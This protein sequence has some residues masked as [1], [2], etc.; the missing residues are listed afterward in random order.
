MNKLIVIAEKGEFKLIE[1][2]QE[3]NL[4]EK[5]IP[6]LVTGVGG[7]NM[8]R[9]LKDLPKDTELINIGYAGSR[10]LPIDQFYQVSLSMLHHPDV[11]YDEPAYPLNTISGCKAVPCYTS[12][13]FVLQS[14]IDD[15]LFD[16]DLGFIMPFGF[17]KVTSFKFVSDNLNFEEHHE[18]YVGE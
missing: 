7:F 1:R 9:S 5:S 8:I 15:C 16:M 13:N 2:L 12:T 17:K 18:R 10:N 11:D 6:V 14:D 3:M 4:V